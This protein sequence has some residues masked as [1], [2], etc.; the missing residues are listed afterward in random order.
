MTTVERRTFQRSPAEW[1]N[2]AEAGEEIIVQSRGRTPLTIKAGKP[3][4]ASKQTATDW[5]EH[6]R[7]VQS[8]PPVD[9]KLL[10]ALLRRDR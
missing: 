6:F 4:A 3:A 5:D 10:A 7:W 9:E 2:R 1:L 8:Q